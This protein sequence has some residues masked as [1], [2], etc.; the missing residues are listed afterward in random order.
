MR[1]GVRFRL[2]VPMLCV[3]PVLWL[4]GP[5]PGGEEAPLLPQERG[6][7]PAAS[8]ASQQSVTPQRA[9][10]APK[11]PPIAPESGGIILTPHPDKY[12]SSWSPLLGLEQRFSGEG[13]HPNSNTF[14][15]SLSAQAPLK[16]ENFFS[17][18][19][20]LLTSGRQEMADAL[21]SLFQSFYSPHAY[22]F[23]W[24]PPLEHLETRCFGILLG[25]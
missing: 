6:A 2:L 23:L 25:K 8:N 19:L 1:R 22:L 21:R 20:Y 18:G 13:K 14:L 7:D 9:T 15:C 11:R 5:D 3:L 10:R 4:W 12:N 17:V 16:Q 24:K